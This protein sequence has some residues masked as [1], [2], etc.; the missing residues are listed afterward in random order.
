MIKITVNGKE[1]YLPV[2]WNDV[3]YR[4]FC[5][6]QEFEVQELGFYFEYYT[7]I[8]P[9]DFPLL[10]DDLQLKSFYILEFL[11]KDNEIE[12]VPYKGKIQILT[13]PFG[14]YLSAQSALKYEGG[15]RGIGNVVKSYTNIDVFYIPIT[16]AIPIINYFTEQLNALNDRYK[17]LEISHLTSQE[18]YA[19][20]NPLTNQ[21]CFEGLELVATMR[22]LGARVDEWD[23]FAETV[24][25]FYLM[26]TKLLNHREQ[27][28]QMRLRDAMKIS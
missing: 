28:Y 23:K 14:K 13:E 19:M 20:N 26:E 11:L 15:F 5:H 4:D 6:F 3:T 17:E 2:T 25:L 1:K 8:K 22:M 18:S 24:P 9:D 10:P 7:G 21:D 27:G 12:Y 16:Q